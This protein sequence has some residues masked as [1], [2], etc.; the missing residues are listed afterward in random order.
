M[1]QTIRNLF[2]APAHTQASASTPDWLR[3]PLSH[4]VL[5]QM[6]PDELADLPLGRVRF[7]DNRNRSASDRLC[8]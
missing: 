3:D 8:A 6:T 1:L 5:D 4:P 2:S 7:D